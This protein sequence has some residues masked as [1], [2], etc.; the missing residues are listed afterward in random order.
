M[1]I[2]IDARG[3]VKIAVRKTFSRTWWGNAW[4]EAMARI[5]YNTNRL[6]VESGS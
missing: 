2:I 1:V 3:D 5:D 4:V 6:L